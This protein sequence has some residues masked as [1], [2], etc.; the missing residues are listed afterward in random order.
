MK[1]NEV[2]DDLT[3][4]EKMMS[5]I[6][7]GKEEIKRRFSLLDDVPRDGKFKEIFKKVEENKADYLKSISELEQLVVKFIQQEL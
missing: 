4:I 2:K 6:Y 7:F 3:V 5:E 1:E